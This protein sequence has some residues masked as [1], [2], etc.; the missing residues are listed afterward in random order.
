MSIKKDPDG[1]RSVSVEVEVPGTPEQ[2]WQAIATGPGISAWFV[3]TQVEGRNGGEIVSDFG[4]GMKSTAKI[5]AWEPPLRFAATDPGWAP[6]MPP[7]ATEWTV[8]SKGGGTCIVRVVHSLFA[9]TDDWDKQIE[10]TETGWASFF[11]VLRRYLQQFAGQPSA[12]VQA[13]A[14]TNEPVAKA[15]AALSAAL[16][17]GGL[18]SGQPL[19]LELAPGVALGGK[20]ERIDDLGHGH[21][22]QVLLDTPAPGTLLVGAYACGGTMVS[23]SAYLYGP[24]AKQ[25]AT[26]TQPHLSSWIAAQFPAPSMEAS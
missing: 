10:G 15:W 14:M 26:A 18:K 8:E 12:L 9:S 2:V 1:R 17:R 25:A 21:N 13:T 3:T 23:A 6:G 16:H 5:T 4:A 24:R 19:S 7:V 11:R 22:L 20:I